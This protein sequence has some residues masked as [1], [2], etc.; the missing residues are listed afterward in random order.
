[1]IDLVKADLPKDPG[2]GNHMAQP[3]IA[4]W[5]EQRQAERQEALDLVAASQKLFEQ[6][7][8]QTSNSTKQNFCNL[9]ESL[10]SNDLK[11]VFIGEFSR[12]NQA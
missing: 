8:S 11:L 3:S 5:L 12:A 9:T 7:G 2:K 6:Y 10:Q 4:E 1:M